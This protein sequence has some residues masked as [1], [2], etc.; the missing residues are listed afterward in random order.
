MKAECS[1]PSGLTPGFFKPHVSSFPSLWQHNEQETT[2]V[3]KPPFHTLQSPNFQPS[4]VLN[5]T[6][7]PHF[8]MMQQLWRLSSCP[9][10]LRKPS[11]STSFLVTSISGTPTELIHAPWCCFHGW[12]MSRSGCCWWLACGPWTCFSAASVSCCPILP[13][14]WALFL[15]FS[16]WMQKP[17]HHV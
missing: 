4:P 6:I 2:T 5:D 1:S 15:N 17:S 10:G 7:K 12:V 13:Q 14:E 8:F 3:T 9:L 16:Q 11:P